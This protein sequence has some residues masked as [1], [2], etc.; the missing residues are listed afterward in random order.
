M[1]PSPQAIRYSYMDCGSKPGAQLNAKPAVACTTSSREPLRAALRFA[2]VTPSAKDA[3]RTT[4]RPGTAWRRAPFCASY[5][6]SAKGAT[7]TTKQARICWA[8]H[9]VLRE[10]LQSAK[11]ATRTTNRPGT[12]WRRAPFCASYS[13]AQWVRRAPPNR[14][15]TASRRAPFLR[16]LLSSSR[17]VPNDEPRV[18]RRSFQRNISLG[19]NGSRRE[20]E[21][22]DGF[23]QIRLRP[24]FLAARGDHGR[25]PLLYQEQR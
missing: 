23:A 7:R 6:K 14:P 17:A 12:A 2:R 20:L 24:P 15:E 25:L 16:E 8:P 1:S 18:T 19:Q 4:N 9:S 11:D 10:L 5:S 3:T 22:R 13:K 21:L